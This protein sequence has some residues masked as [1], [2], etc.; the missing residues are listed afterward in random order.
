MLTEE[1]L[2]KYDITV[3]CHI[4]CHVKAILTCNKHGV[5]CKKYTIQ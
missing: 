3:I 4:V 2:L 5:K 1:L